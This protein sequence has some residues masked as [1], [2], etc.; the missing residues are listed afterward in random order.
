MIR[1]PQAEGRDEGATLAQEVSRTVAALQAAGLPDFEVTGSEAVGPAI[2]ADLRRKGA[3]ATLASIAG[4]TAYIA[5]RFRPSFA[6]GAI[7]A[8]LHDILVTVAIVTASGYDVSLNVVAAI[9]TI[10]GYSVN[11]TIVTFDRVRENLRA[12]PGAPLRHV[13]NTAVNQTL[14]RTT[15]TAL[16]TFLAVLALFVFGGDV[17]RGFA[18]TLLVGIVS[19]TYSTIFIAAAIAVMVSKARS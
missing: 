11:D 13:V 19:G 18:F 17:L 5:I 9:L 7:A 12:M 16:T 3:F 8:T 14:G 1:L 2:G 4:I 10:T 15:I 6:A